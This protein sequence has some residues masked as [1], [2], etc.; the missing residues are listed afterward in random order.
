[1]NPTSGVR[2]VLV[3]EIPIA[4]AVKNAL[5]PALSCDVASVTVIAPAGTEATSESRAI[6]PTR[7]LTTETPLAAYRARRTL[8]YLRNTPRSIN[9]VLD[10][11]LAFTFVML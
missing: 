8:S 5:P 11:S 9:G 10:D 6:T 3:D 2:P 7:T 1:M 4:V